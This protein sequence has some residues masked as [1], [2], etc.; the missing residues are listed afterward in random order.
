MPDMNDVVYSKN[1]VLLTLTGQVS[2]HFLDGHIIEG[3]FASQD[4]LNIFLIVDGEPVMIPRG[5]I[6]FI[7]GIKGQQIEVDISQDLLLSAKLPQEAITQARRPDL[8]PA[9]IPVDAYDEEEE[10][11]GTLVL[12][13]EASQPAPSLVEVDEEDGTLVL[14]STEVDS[15]VASLQELT[16]APVDIDELDETDD[17]TVVLED[18]TGRPGGLEADLDDATLVLQEEKEEAELSASLTC[19]SGPHA[20]EVF[21]IGSGI[22]TMGRSSDNVICLGNDKEISRHHAIVLQESGHYVVQDQNSLNGTF[23]NDEQ[24]TGPRYL[25]NGDSILVGLSSLKFQ[26]E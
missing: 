10:D 19:T 1:P 20:G 15:L 13:P 3:E 8:E 7:K 2:V 11:E 16:P 23:V 4:S 26:E 21:Q 5:Q 24:I 9:A 6:R 25:E 18:S 17:M 12:V 14:D 22:I